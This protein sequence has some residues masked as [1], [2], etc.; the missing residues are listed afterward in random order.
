MRGND[1]P[2][3]HRYGMLSGASLPALPAPAVARPRVRGNDVPPATATVIP[4]LA[5]VIPAP[6][7]VIPAEAGIQG[8]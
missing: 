2:P 4:A 6:A 3:G 1:V 7:A 8:G 5:T